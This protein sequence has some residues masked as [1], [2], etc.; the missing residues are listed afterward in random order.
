MKASSGFYLMNACCRPAAVLSSDLG[1]TRARSEEDYN[2]SSQGFSESVMN[3]PVF[4]PVFCW[5]ILCFNNRA[6]IHKW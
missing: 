5:L 6:G 3:Y 4:Y 1:N 2:S